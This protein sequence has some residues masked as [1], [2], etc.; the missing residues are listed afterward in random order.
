MEIRFGSAKSPRYLCNACQHKFF[1]KPTRTKFCPNCSEKLHYTKVETDST[2]TNQ[3]ARKRSRTREASP[4]VQPV[5]SESQKVLDMLFSELKTLLDNVSKLVKNRRGCEKIMNRVIKA[6][7]DWAE[8]DEGDIETLM[9]RPTPSEVIQKIPV[10]SGLQGS[11]CSI[12]YEEMLPQESL[13]ELNCK[14]RFHIDC[15]LPWLQFKNTCPD[16]RALIL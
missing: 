13:N 6:L 7:N 11:T 14:H 10:V 2:D 8:S 5:S 1:R 12:C 9:V 16:C 4:V 15:L 3:R